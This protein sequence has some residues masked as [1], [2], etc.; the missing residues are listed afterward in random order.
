MK[1]LWTDISIKNKRGSLALIALA[2]LLLAA[3]GTATSGLP[4]RETEFGQIVPVEGEAQYTD[5]IPQELAAM[6]EDK[7][8]FFVNVHVPYEGELPNTDAFIPFDQIADFLDEF[9]EDTNSKVVLYCRSGSMSATAAREL[10]RLG[11][12]NVFNLDG[13]FRA[14]SAAGYEF[15]AP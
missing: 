14:W 2:G 5:I 7:D 4:T 15:I 1:F 6:L 12:S 10:V 8:F 3:C 13:G 11:F 9:P